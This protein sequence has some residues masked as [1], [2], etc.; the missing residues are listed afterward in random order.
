MKR[1]PHAII[2]G[3]ATLLLAACT[4]RIAPCRHVLHCGR[5]G[6]HGDSALCLPVD[7]A[8]PEGNYR[9]YL[10]LR[11]TGERNYPFDAL[12]VELESHHDTI[13]T[14]RDTLR[15]PLS[16]REEPFAARGTTCLQYDFPLD[17]LRVSPASRD[18]FTLR[19]IMRRNPLPGVLDV[20]LRL[21]QE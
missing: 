2:A 14:R 7:T 21:E 16:T 4:A 9:L 15:L 10:S 11:L 12:A 18:T 6:W 20:T 8:L 1:T 3:T 17:T 13:P 5:A 19:H